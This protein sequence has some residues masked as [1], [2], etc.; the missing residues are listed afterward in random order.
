MSFA[1]KQLNQR[2]SPKGAG[3]KGRLFDSVMRVPEIT[4]TT[5]VWTNLAYDDLG[6][7]VSASTS[8]EHFVIP[9]NGRYRIDGSFAFQRKDVSDGEKGNC[10]VTILLVSG[11]TEVGVAYSRVATCNNSSAT[12][13]TI[14]AIVSASA[15]QIIYANLY[16]D[17]VSASASVSFGG[18]ESFLALELIG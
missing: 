8:F 9:V 5:A 16:W 14:T 1:G 10:R 13:N 15:G 3:V 2:T 17:H 12:T 18:L 6:Y 4:N 11:V 7:V